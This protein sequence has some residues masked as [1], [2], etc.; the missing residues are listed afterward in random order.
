MWQKNNKSDHDFNRFA[1]NKLQKEISNYPTFYIIIFQI[2]F[3]LESIALY[4]RIFAFR[5]LP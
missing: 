2:Y 1:L 4:L 3:L 5:Q